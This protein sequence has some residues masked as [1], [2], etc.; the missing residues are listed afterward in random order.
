[1]KPPFTFSCNAALLLVIAL[2][3][4]CDPSSVNDMSGAPLP[5][6]GKQARFTDNHGWLPIDEKALADLLTLP[7]P[8]PLQMG[9]PPEQ[10]SKMLNDHLS[11]NADRLIKQGRVL[12]VKAGTKV[13][14]LGYYAGESRSIRPL[15]QGEKIAGF[16]KVE[17]LE[18]D[19][20]QKTGFATSDSVKY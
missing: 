1:M 11:T 5:Q 7:T 14:I 20:Q 16:V 18:G 6:V 13:R 3:T 8:N 10:A 17:V 4:A 15:G 9:V 19:A 2:V 12:E